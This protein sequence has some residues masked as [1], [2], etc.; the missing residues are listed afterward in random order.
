MTEKKAMKNKTAFSGCGFV[1]AMAFGG[2]GSG[3]VL[4]RIDF[5]GMVASIEHRGP[6]AEGTF[7]GK[8]VLLG[9]RRLSILDLSERGNQP[10]TRGHLTIVSNGEV[11][12]FESIRRELEQGGVSFSSHTDTE[13]ILRAYEKWGPAALHKFNGMFAFAIWDEVKKTL[14]IARDRIGIKPFY[15]F[16]DNKVLLFGSE[17]QA[18]MHSRYIPAEINW[19]A[20][21]GQIIVNSLYQHHLHRTLVKNVFALPPGHFMTVNAD[22]QVKT[23]KYWD[24]PEAPENRG[25]T[26]EE[27]VEHL[28]ELFEDSI[29]LRLVSDV[30]VAAFLSGGMDSSVI[31]AVAARMLKEYKLTAIT[32][33]YEGGG[34]NLYTG[35]EDRDLAF[36]RIVAG[37]LGDKVRHNVIRVKPAGIT[38]PAIDNIIDLASFTDD[39]RLL[40]IF[41]NYR[42]VK[43]QNFKVVLNG[44]GADEILGGYIAVNYIRKGIFD[45]KNPG[46]DLIRHA[47]PYLSIPDENT[48][49]KELLQ[50]VDDVYEDLH[51]FYRQLPGE[52]LEKAH[53]FLVKTELQGILKFEDHLS[54]R[55]SIECRVPFLDHR[56]IEWAFRTPFQHHVREEDM[57][58]KML[59][60]DAARSFLPKNVIDRPKQ[61]F[62]VADQQRTENALR[63]IFRHHQKEISRSEIIRR[64]YKKELTAQ[65]EPTVS[66][67]DLWIIIALWRWENKL[68]EFSA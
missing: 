63:K 14:F 2:D 1:G 53:R 24:L 8:G 34:K 54:M 30:P 28:K 12:N 66:S 33:A 5:K 52:P 56:L 22:G 23:G 62:P 18:L 7:R 20:V 42:T 19:E 27:L 6:E 49:S 65:Q 25:N 61:P 50:D 26:R 38:V 55:S 4:N 36:S 60:R 59:L 35:E 40:T 43:E 17:V 46:K 37:T 64:V 15:Y 48:L 57:M 44:Q 13:V 11:Y 58:G 47:F 32:V 51:G 39:E 10:M 31:S 29:R 41:G 3:G 45:I 9:H 21:Y 67:R 16:K 68:K